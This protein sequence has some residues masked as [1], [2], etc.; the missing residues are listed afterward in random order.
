MRIEIAIRECGI[1]LT[2]LLSATLAADTIKKEDILV[3]G[4]NDRVMSLGSVDPTTGSSQILASYRSP[5]FEFGAVGVAVGTSGNLITVSSENP[6][7][8][9]VVSFDP[10][11]HAT[12]TISL[13]NL[14]V[15][16]FGIIADAT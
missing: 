7:V 6:S 16:P 8:F 2:L 11:T 12:T 5:N 15:D 1:A 13:G 14:L 3:S 9:G 4:F 10:S